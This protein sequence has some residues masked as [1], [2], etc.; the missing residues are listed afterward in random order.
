[1]QPQY[2]AYH[3]SSVE[4]VEAFSPQLRIVRA[5]AYQTRNE[6]DMFSDGCTLATQLS[7]RGRTGHF[8]PL[9]PVI[10]NRRQSCRKHSRAFW[11]SDLLPLLRL[12]RNPQKKNSL[13]SSRNR[14]RLNRRRPANTEQDQTGRAFGPVL[15]PARALYPE[16]ASC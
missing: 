2:V 7:S 13:L 1:M 12:V 16:G 5:D 4:G 6:F 8:A 9:S 14:F 11:L 15:T 10:K 3:S